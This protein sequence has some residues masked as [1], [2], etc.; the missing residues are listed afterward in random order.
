MLDEVLRNPERYR[1]MLLP[2]QHSPNPDR[3]EAEVFGPQ[4]ESWK[5]FREMQE[6]NRGIYNVE[7]RFAA[8]FEEE[9]RGKAE[10]DPREVEKWIERQWRDIRAR[11]ERMQKEEGVGEAGYLDFVEKNKQISI[12]KG[13]QW[14]GLTDDESRQQSRAEFDKVV[15]SQ[16]LKTFRLLR[17]DKG[18]GGFAGYVA[19]AR[20][21]LAK[22]GFTQTFQL[23][24]DPTR[25]DKMTTWIE[26]LIYVCSWHDVY[27]RACERL[28]P[29]FDEARKKLVD[30]GVLRSGETPESVPT[31]EQ[32]LQDEQQLRLTEKSVTSAEAAAA[33]ALSEVERSKTAGSGL[34]VQAYEVG[35]VAARSELAAAK[36]AYESIKRRCNMISKFGKDTTRY[37]QEL[38]SL[39]LQRY[40]VQWVLQQIPLIEKELNGPEVANSSSP[41]AGS[42]RNRDILHQDDGATGD[43]SPTRRAAPS[44]H[45]DDLG[46]SVQLR[47][48]VV[49]AEAGRPAKR[50][51][52]EP[53]PQ[54]DDIGFPTQL[55]EDNAS[56]DEGRPTKRKSAEPSPQPDD[57][58]SAEQSGRPPKR[59][60]SNSPLQSLET[61]EALETS[62][63][64]S[65]HVFET[66]AEAPI[67]GETQVM[68]EGPEGSKAS[69][70]SEVTT[71]TATSK[72]R[73][74]APR[75]KK[76]TEQPS[77][78][79][80]TASKG[81]KAAPRG[82]NGAKPPS[83][84]ATTAA[85][86]AASKGKKATAKVTTTALK[87][88]R[89]TTS[90]VT[91]KTTN[92]IA[93]VPNIKTRS[94]SKIERE[95]EEA[96][97]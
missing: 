49:S 52:A 24:M 73:K 27:E 87:E 35:L 44:P 40:R 94:R 65:R 26:Y 25:Q 45:P 17:E 71:T 23:D 84:V 93:T 61:P 83:T 66:A 30:S 12:K 4:L 60:R 22:H 46:S 63:P 76:G 97:V 16:S 7:E 36:D 42:G 15:Y 56:A 34:T 59:S 72:G 19:E 10:E 43:G 85:S 67:L 48:V 1:E 74:A 2:W 20:R 81:R 18:K 21:R 47:K 28:Q 86:T 91:K 68:P 8:Y 79:T 32:G 14:P 6:H 33:A 55:D 96:T 58:G 39:Q 78:V 88:T 9:R 92:A 29:K 51:S 82:K 77:T 50:K 37:Q 5:E 11:F 75:G 69:S 62:Q 13:F 57:M 80:T 3:L 31:M 90:R 38:T 89:T 70:P 54:P 95:T 41:S 53:C 64:A